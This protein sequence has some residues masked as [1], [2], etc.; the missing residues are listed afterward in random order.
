MTTITLA[1]KPTLLS[2]IK[3]RIY[4][5]PHRR[6]RAKRIEASQRT[7]ID[8]LTKPTNRV[9]TPL[10]VQSATLWRMINNA[11][12]SGQLDLTTLTDRPSEL[13]KGLLYLSFERISGLLDDVS[14]PIADLT[15]LE[16]RTI[17][18]LLGGVEAEIISEQSIDTTGQ[19]EPRL[20][21]RLPIATLINLN[22]P[23][24]KAQLAEVA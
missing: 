22:Q 20:A 1:T 13:K 15:S 24:V 4:G 19:G 11:I 17:M 14:L 16:F 18:T 3:R 7:I 2:Q 6:H 21:Y 5:I 23:I 10:P 8:H 12:I 9:Y